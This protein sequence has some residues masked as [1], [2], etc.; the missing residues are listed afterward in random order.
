MPDSDEQYRVNL[1]NETITQLTEML[2]KGGLAPVQ[3]RNLQ[4]EIDYLLKRRQVLLRERTPWKRYWMRITQSVRRFL[5][6][7]P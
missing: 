4:R 2:V 5:H 6:M 7:Y 3:R 1:I